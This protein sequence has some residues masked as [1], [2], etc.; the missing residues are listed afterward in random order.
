MSDN[1]THA[2]DEEGYIQFQPASKIA[3]Q[4][5]RVKHM[6]Q[7]WADQVKL[8]AL[9]PSFI[10]DP[11]GQKTMEVIGT[12]VHVDMNRP[13]LTVHGRELGYKFMAAEAWWILSGRDDVESIKPYSKDI[14][15]FSD[16]AKTFFG[17]YGPRIREQ[18]DH[19]VN[20]L[21]NDPA[22]RQAVLTIW[23]PNPPKTK[24]TPCTITMQFII[25]DNRLHCLTTMRSSDIWLGLP[26]DV[27]NFT[28]VA[29]MVM[30]ELRLLSQFAHLSLGALIV[31]MGSS[32]MYD[33]NCFGAL[34]CMAYN[35]IGWQPMILE[36][37]FKKYIII[38]IS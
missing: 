16:D 24:D 29:S 27:F 4:P 20:S 18:L 7:A 6:N 12:Q 14:A 25:R 22:S 35:F 3:S 21:K 26:Y 17:A 8:L 9:R 19:C 5:S 36:E 15:N 28:M 31:T 13:V 33:R 11:R 10:S 30:L 34:Q 23:R 2:V 1:K 38:S 37:V 32:H